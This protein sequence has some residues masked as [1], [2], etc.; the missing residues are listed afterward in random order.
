MKIN[1]SVMDTMYEQFK[2]DCNIDE[3]RMIADGI[4]LS[5]SKI[6][7]G[8][9]IIDKTDPFLRVVVFMGKAYVMADESIL[10]G[11]EELFKDYKPEWF[12]SF[13]NLRTIDHIL[14]EYGREIVDTHI[15]FLPDEDAKHVEP[16][17]NEIWIDELEIAQMKGKNPFNKALC[18]SATQPDVIAV[19]AVENGRKIAMAGASKDGKY[20]YQIGIDVLRE[21]EGRGLATHLVSLLRQRLLDEGKLPFYGTCE[22][23]AVSRSI[24]VKAGF[25]P[26]F[27]EFSVKKLTKDDKK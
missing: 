13:N 5:P 27:S 12:F 18:Y 7:E 20:A 11:C 4:Y 26:A 6:L 9:R 24:A 23:H 25:L 1:K 16:S 22:S 21:Y 14:R 17:G 8:A 15:Y 19:A 10:G 2:L 3:A